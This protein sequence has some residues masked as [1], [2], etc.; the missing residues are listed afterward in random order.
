MAAA[1]VVLQ[2]ADVVE[3]AVALRTRVAFPAWCRRGTVRAPH[4]H[5][6]LVLGK[7]VMVAGRAA[8]HLG[9]YFD[10]LRCFLGF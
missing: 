4:M 3:A 8:E 2:I 1:A 9:G 6:Q 7:E 10:A 5:L